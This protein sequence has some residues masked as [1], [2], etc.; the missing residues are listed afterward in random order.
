MLAK[1]ILVPVDFSDC[2]LRAL[3]YAYELARK[4]DA[5]IQLLHCV[6][7]LSPEVS[8]A[9]T[10]SMIDTLQAGA[11]QALDKLVAARPNVAF[12]TPLIVRMDPRDA[13]LEVAQ[14]KKADLIVIGTHGRR[15]LSRL[16]LGSVAEEVLRRAPCP[17]LTLRGG[18]S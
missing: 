1:N 12:E 17:V 6:G 8:L 7:P 16:V 2:S 5:K 11:V 4:L 10:P 14:T 13:I 9:L 3:D 15:G 18:V